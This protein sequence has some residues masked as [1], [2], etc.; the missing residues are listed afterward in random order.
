M[1]L[2]AVSGRHSVL[3]APSV[4]PSDE[5]SEESRDPYTAK[6]LSSVIP[7]ERPLFLPDPLRSLPRAKPR[8]R[9]ARV[10]GP[11]VRCERL[12]IYE[13]PQILRLA[14]GGL[15][16]DDKSEWMPVACAHNRY[17]FVS[18]G[19][20]I[21]TERSA[22]DDKT[23]K[24]G[25][26]PRVVSRLLLPDQRITHLPLKLKALT[27]ISLCHRELRAAKILISN[28]PAG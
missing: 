9:G 25:T 18:I 22:Q 4:I 13:E 1:D 8:G 5:R 11:A 2:S 27:F 14:R 17:N 3:T 24:T 12:E 6:I 20:A 28:R 15:A 16:Q 7:S 23:E 10:E 21:R 26:S 19:F